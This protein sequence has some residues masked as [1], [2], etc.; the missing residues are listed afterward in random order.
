[1]HKIFELVCLLLLSVPLV[2][3]AQQIE[4]ASKPYRK[5]VINEGI[6]VALDLDHIDG[7]KKPGIFTEGDDI[8]VRFSISDTLTKSGLSGAFPAAWMDP[9]PEEDDDC[10]KKVAS[11]ITGSILNQAELNLNVYY[12]LALN[13][14]PTITVVDP[15]F[16]YGGSQLLA[17]IELNS[18][19]MDWV[20][21]KDQNFIF[22]S[23]P[24]AKQIAV[25]STAN[26]SLVRNIDVPAAPHQLSLQKDGQYLWATCQGTENGLAVLDVKAQ[27]LE[28]F[29][30]MAPGNYRLL[31]SEED[32]YV[33]ATNDQEHTLSIIETNTFQNLNQLKICT[34]PSGMAY[35]KAAKAIYVISE[36]TGELTVID[37]EQQVVKSSLNLEP[38]I[39]QIAFEPTERYAFVVNTAQDNISILDAS[40][41]KVVQVGDMESQPDQVTFTESLAYVRH[42]NSELILM[43]PLANIGN[44]NRPVTVVDFPGGQYP[45]GKMSAA[46]LASG[47]VQAP[48]ESAVLLANAPDKTVYFY[49]EGMAAPMGNFNNYNQEPR[50]VMVIDRSL[51]ESSSGVYETVVKLRSPGTYDMAFFMDV[52]RFIHCFRLEVQPD[53]ALVK[54]RSIQRNGALTVQHLPPRRYV[55]AGEEFPINFKLVDKKSKAMQTDLEDVHIMC[56]GNSGAHHFRKPV[57]VNSDGVYSTTAIFKESGVYYMYVQSEQGGLS[58]SNPQ[59]RTL[60]VKAASSSK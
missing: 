24:E 32:Q 56:M 43:I 23:M 27:E 14:E 7:K 13:A 60:H 37:V 53:E 21:S 42:K 4:Q 51:Q 3:N 11:F 2:V 9:I 52:P 8:R 31:I 58:L 10:V 50:A 5:A 30:P 44:E 48:G 59:Y 54:Q 33:F 40:I 22:V 46:C 26:W 35:S 57:K 38:G 16:G 19:G 41:N 18:P 25:I 45:A 12:V 28:T 49:M 34:E 15:L 17:L 39:C 6:M 1:M 47:M 36:T 29:I 55:T 20:V